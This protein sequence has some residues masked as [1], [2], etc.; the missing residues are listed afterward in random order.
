M[1][2]N[3]WGSGCGPCRNEAPDRQAA[4]TE[5]SE[6][7]RFLG[8]T[9]KDYDPAPAEAFVRAFKITYPSLDDPTGTTLLAFAG[10]GDHHHPEDPAD[11]QPALG[12]GL[13][14]GARNQAI[15]GLRRPQLTGMPIGGSLPV[16]VDQLLVTGAWGSVTA[17][18]RQ[19]AASFETVI[20]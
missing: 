15:S 18:V 4:S 1:V 6:I 3:V 11:H 14:G 8:I 10:Q 16:V 7:A 17:T 9:S 19:W 5:T 2:I 13:A 20:S 12:Q